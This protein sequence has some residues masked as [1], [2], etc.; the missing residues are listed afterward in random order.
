MS[1]L[2]GLYHYYYYYYF[3]FYHLFVYDLNII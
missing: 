2:N 3:K 1:V